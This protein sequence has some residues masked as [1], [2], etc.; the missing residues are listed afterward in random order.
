MFGTKFR[1]VAKLFQNAPE[2]KDTHQ[3][4]ILGYNGL[5]QERSFQK[6]LTR[7][8]GTNFCINCTSLVRFAAS[9]V[10]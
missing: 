1:E 9:F 6:I 3:N 2:Q 7:H 5:D 8:L 4:M 10:Q